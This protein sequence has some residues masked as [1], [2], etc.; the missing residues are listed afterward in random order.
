MSCNHVLKGVS[1]R[2]DAQRN[3]DRIVEVARAFFRS[4]GFDAV[5]MDEVAKGAE[6]GPG[7]LYR[8][9]PTKES[10]Y[11]A[12]LEAWAEKVKS[13]VDHAIA[14]DAPARVRLITWLTDYAAMLTEHKGAAA[15]ITAALGDP[16][17]P[18]AAKCQTYLSAN[19][20]L[21]DELDSALRP[22]VEAIQISR[23][24]GGVAAVADNSGLPSESVASMLAIVADGLLSST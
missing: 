24:V 9:F 19:Q 10:L 22:G 17:S 6:V 18:F 20:R 23:L 5:S 15:R 12:V 13:A 3:R 11:D 2:A 7:T 14:L 1:V 16:G 4:K 21:I 8:H